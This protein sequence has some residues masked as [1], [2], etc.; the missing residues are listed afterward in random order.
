MRRS[1]VLVAL[2]FGVAFVPLGSARILDVPGNVTTE[3]TGPGGAIVSYDAGDLICTPA[4][5]SLFPL[6][7]TEVDCTNPD[8]TPAGSFTVTVEDTTAPVITVP[9]DISVNGNGPT[10]VNYTEP[11]ATD[12]VD[13]PVTPSCSSHSGDTFPIGTTTVNCSAQDH[14]GNTSSAS[15]HV[16]VVDNQPPTFTSVP[17]NATLE[18][19]GPGGA[20]FSYS[21]S[22]SDNADPSPSI[23]C[24]HP[25]GSTFPLGTTTV[26]CTATDNSGNSAQASFTV[27]VIDSHPPTFTSVPSNATVEATGPGGAAVG[28]S[29]SASDNV[30]PSPSINCDHASGSTFPLGTTTVHCT[31]TDNSN[32][33]AQASFT[34]TVQDTTPPVL[35]LPGDIT[36]PVGTA[37]TFSATAHDLVDGSV[38]VSCNHASGS[39]FPLGTTTV[40]CSATDSHGNKASGTFHVTVQDVNPPVLSNV[41]GPIKVEANS[42]A[43][44]VVNFSTP[45]ATDD[46]DG[47]I[48]NVVCAPASGSTF[49]LGTTTVTCS[50]SDSSG[51]TGTASFTVEVVDTTPP[52]L[53]PPGDRSVYAT[54]PA[55]IYDA[56][57]A[58]NAFLGGFTVSDL[59]DPHPVVTNDA[60]NFFFLGLT[61]VTFTA[62]DAS[63][64][65]SKAQ[66]QLNVLPMPEPGTTPPPLPPPKDRTPPGDVTNVVVTSGDGVVTITWDNPNDSDFDHTEITR[67]TTNVGAEPH[68]VYNG[69]ATSLRDKNVQNGVEY[70]YIITAVDKAGNTSPGVVEVAFPKSSGLLAPK[71]GARVKSIVKFKWKKVKGARYYNLQAFY[72]STRVFAATADAKVL[73]AWPTKAS[74]VLKKTWKYLGRKRTLKAG[75]Y[76]WYVWPGFGPRSAAEYGELIGS[77][78]FTVVR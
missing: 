29:I 62:R 77:R 11:T 58:A 26:I 68:V 66:A 9:A 33:S 25:S 44:S 76:T 71:A 75:V 18:A 6:G 42:H 34:V 14:A 56:D 78:S 35:S 3:A 2:L 15:F 19:T 73:S 31:A 28:Y 43:G 39:A 20:A 30:D 10:V 32:N 23:N 16:T 8:T 45:T 17:S 40:S 50:A 74:F 27:T 70:R 55:G 1:L 67:S 7:T 64:N 4:S 13:G 59:A 63:G 72:G 36:V 52:L 57:E 47:L 5:G 69:K 48:A 53:I 54:Y 65:T 21:I 60:P 24:N 12:I 22:A 49:A 41:P 61:V 46:V 38:A 51:N 37:V